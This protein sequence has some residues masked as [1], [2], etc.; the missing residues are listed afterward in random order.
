LH[1]EAVRGVAKAGTTV[2]FQIGRVKAQCAH[3]WDEMFWEF[4]RAM[5]RNDF[6]H[7][8]L[9]HKTPGP[10]ARCAFFLREQLFDAVIIQRG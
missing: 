5:A 1:D 4:A 3:A 7:H 6:G 8:F 10:I 2:F 9:V